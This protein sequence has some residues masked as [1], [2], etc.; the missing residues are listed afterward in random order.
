MTP[1][2]RPLFEQPDA[3][4]LELS[5]RHYEADCHFN[6]DLGQFQALGVTVSN[7]HLPVVVKAAQPAFKDYGFAFQILQDLDITEVILRHKHGAERVSVADTATICSPGPLLAGLLGI[8]VETAGQPVEPELHI[9][10][11]IKVQPEPS[12]DVPSPVSPGA[13][14]EPIKPEPAPEPDLMGP[15]SPADLPGD[16]PI[17]RALTPEEIEA[18]V[19]MVKVMQPAQRKLFTIAFRNAFDVPDTVNRIASEIKQVRHLQ[20]IDRFTVEAAGGIA[21]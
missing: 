19:G 5:R 1:P 16:H 10:E 4:S 18:A 3:I 7:Y 2:E 21:A 20:F 17:L 6:V 8:P 13:P 14:A 15:D 9:D 11:P 12:A